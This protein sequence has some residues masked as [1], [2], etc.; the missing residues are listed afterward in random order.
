VIAVA[1]SRLV[2]GVGPDWE[3]GWSVVLWAPKVKGSNSP[4]SD[5]KIVNRTDGRPPKPFIFT[6]M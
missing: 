5:A 2:V 1:G 4:S 6:P 3:A